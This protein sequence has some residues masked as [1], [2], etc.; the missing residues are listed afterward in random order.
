MFEEEEE[1]ND[2]AYIK[3]YLDKALPQEEVIR[4]E[5]R[6]ERDHAFH[7]LFE[8]MVLMIQGIR[9]FSRKENLDKLKALEGSMSQKK[10]RGLMKNISL[11]RSLRY[12]AAAAVFALLAITAV[13]VMQ[14][15]VKDVNELYAQNYQP[16]PNVFAPTVRGEATPTSLYKKAFLA[17]DNSN[18]EEAA[19]LFKQLLNESEDSIKGRADIIHFYLGNS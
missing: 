18:Y 13:V 14:L 3:R 2:I 12:W 8:E 17:Y 16:F 15:S 9:A 7:S 6:L 11:S 1:E 4:F 19:I 10:S 5:E